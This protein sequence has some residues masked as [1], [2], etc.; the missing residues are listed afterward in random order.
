VADGERYLDEVGRGLNLGHYESSAILDELR[1]H[2]RAAIDDYRRRGEEPERAVERAIGRLGPA[3]TL[4]RDLDRAHRTPR[5]RFAQTLD[6]LRVVASTA[7]LV[8]G[9]IGSVLWAWSAAA[10]STDHVDLLPTTGTVDN[11]MAGYVADGIARAGNEGAKALIIQLNTPGGSLDAMQKIVTSIL[12]APLPVIVWVAPQGAWAASAGTFIT[13]SGNLALM[14]PGTTIG[15]ASPVDSSGNDIT[16]TEG[17]KVRNTAIQFITSI[18]QTRHRN[19]DWAVSTVDHARSSAA[20]EAVQLGAVDGIAATTSDVLA[21]ANGR[22]VTVKGQP[23]TLDLA[24][25][26]VNELGMNAFQSFLHLLSDPNIAFILFSIGFYGLLYELIHPN[27]VTGILGGLSLILAFIGSG[28]L[29]LNVAGVLLLGLAVI[30]LF[31]EASVP[32]HGLLAI[33]G[34]IC[35]A[36]GAATFYTTPGPGL[37]NVQVAWPVVGVMA[38]L[39]VLLALV[40][41]R[42]ALSARRMQHALVAPGLNFSGTGTVGVLGEVRRTLAPE[43]SVYVSGEE[44]SARTTSELPIPRGTPVRVVAQ[45][46]LVLVVEPITEHVPAGLP[47]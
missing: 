47:G 36:L 19:V 34:L 3:R 32:S 23:V 29:P 11:V 26:S 42:A 41:L 20:N 21:F 13:L 40:V 22:Q 14:A 8:M 6:T 27:F 30:L 1:Q 45:D 10:A 31:L 44:W 15:A 16:G 2:L 43:G 35:F 39:G 4:A 12:E 7:A 28:S 24:G 17:D 25:A 37:P 33:G 38:S 9:A 18:A 46:G 5:R